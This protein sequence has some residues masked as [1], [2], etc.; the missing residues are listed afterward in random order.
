[1][2]DERINEV[3]MEIILEAGNARDMLQA[4][5]K[6]LETFDFY[7]AEKKFIQAKE[8]LKN[9]HQAQ[10]E[11]IQGEARGEESN[12]SLLFSHA[13]D[14]LM[15]VMSEKNVAYS[16]LNLSKSIDQRILKLEK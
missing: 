5:I 8:H 13:Q 6:K 12:F 3:S 9:A 15:T 7:N 11:T 16:L 4:G 2:N 10:T 14:T 1:M